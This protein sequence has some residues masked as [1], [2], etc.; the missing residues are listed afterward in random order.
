LVAFIG[1]SPDQ[2]I[3]G[4]DRFQKLVYLLNKEYKIFGDLDYFRYYYDPYSRRVEDALDNL[5]IF[6]YIDKQVIYWTTCNWNE[7]YRIDW[8][9]TKKGKT[10]LKRL[11]N[12]H[13]GKLKRIKK[14]TQFL[15]VRGY[16]SLRMKELREIV[17]KLA[18][19][20]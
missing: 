7:V 19:Y 6:G 18:G 8:K 13:K 17:Y 2:T 16:Y 1:S 10:F 11:K 4:K 14:Y 12:E 15:L 3:A 9:L 5:V 20:I